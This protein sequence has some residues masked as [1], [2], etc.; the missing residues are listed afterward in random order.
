VGDRT[1]RILERTGEI[2]DLLDLASSPSQG[3]VRAYS[4]RCSAP[5]LVPIDRDC[6]LVGMA[7]NTGSA[8]LNTTGE[9]YAVCTGAPDGKKNV[10]ILVPSSTA[11]ALKTKIP[12][13]AGQ[14]LYAC[15]SSAGIL[16]T[17][18]FE[19]S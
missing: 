19:D 7:V 9:T 17:C 5:V 1:E 14:A 4:V 12:L 10:L 13:Q 16:I 2:M 11:P 3:H 6:S 18:Y 15:P 8:L